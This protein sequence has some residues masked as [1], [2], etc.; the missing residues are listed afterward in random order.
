MRLLKTWQ[1]RPLRQL[2]NGHG[3]VSYLARLEQGISK[4]QPIEREHLDAYL[5]SHL[6]EPNFLRTNDF[7]GFMA[8][9]QNKLLRLIEAA[10]GKAAYQG[11]MEEGIDVDGDENDVEAQLTLTSGNAK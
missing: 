2:L 8:D 5:R 3:L 4:S 11:D 10:T 9:R 6:I 1:P 7:E